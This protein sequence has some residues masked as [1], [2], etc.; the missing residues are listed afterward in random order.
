[1]KKKKRHYNPESQGVQEFYDKSSGS[2][3][4]KQTPSQ[5]LPGK[6]GRALEVSRPQ[7]VRA[8]S[9]LALAPRVEEAPPLASGTPEAGHG[10]T[11]AQ[12][13]C[14]VGWEGA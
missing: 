4:K 7:Q 8:T 6:E 5:Q 11:V 9:H 13:P 3:G 2:V 1:M 14:P 12:A 10:S